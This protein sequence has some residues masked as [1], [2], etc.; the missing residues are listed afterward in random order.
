LFA[1]TYGIKLVKPSMQ[2]TAAW[3]SLWDES[4]AREVTRR[5]PFLLLAAGDPATLSRQVRENLLAEVTARIAAGERIPVLDTDSLKRYSRPDLADVIRALWDKHASHPEVQRFL[6]R[7]IWLGEINEVG[8]IA[9]KAALGSLADRGTSIVASRSL[10]AAADA[11]SKKQ[12]AAYVKVNCAALPA[13][14]VW[15]ALEKLLP[16][17]VP[18]TLFELM[19]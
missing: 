3:L 15:E 12:Y 5:N 8:D 11:A 13:T 17:C 14:V 16:V 1:E 7:L 4:V 18:K 6:L 19:P 10:M 2:E 9:A